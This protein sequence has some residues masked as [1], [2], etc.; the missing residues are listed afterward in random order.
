MSS[1]DHSGKLLLLLET[2]T[3][4]LFAVLS[5]NPYLGGFGYYNYAI[6]IFF[7]PQAITHA[8]YVSFEKTVKPMSLMDIAVYTLD[9]LEKHQ[10]KMEEYQASLDSRAAQREIFKEI[11]LCKGDIKIWK[12]HLDKLGL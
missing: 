5:F 3:L 10:L 1:E 11:L 2:Y 8:E 4:I 6:L 7:V 12:K 9:M